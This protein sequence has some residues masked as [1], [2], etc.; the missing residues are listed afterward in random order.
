MI[1]DSWNAGDYSRHARFVSDLS[2]EVMQDLS[3]KRGESILDLGCGDGVLT[4]RI[5]DRGCAVIGIDSSPDFVSAAR[6]RGVDARLCDAQSIEFDGMF[7]AVFSNAALHWMK[8][9]HEVGS[10][11]HRAL[12]PG[13]RYVAE[14][15]GQG[16]IDRLSRAIAT[17]LA[18]VGIDYSLCNPWTFPDPKSHSD[19]LSGIGFDVRKCRLRDRPTPLPTDIHGWLSIFARQMLSGL[20]EA[21]RK[22]V[23]NRIVELCRPELCGSDGT[24]WVDY[25][26]LN[27]VAVKPG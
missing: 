14:M 11:V 4:R 20:D 19:M 22:T 25:V 5:M 10:R 12:K 24:W 17:A 8:R 1:D 3:P 9:Q 18:E 26:R 27:F 6:S 2:G 13:G 7:N 16:N 23:L 21:V 15:G